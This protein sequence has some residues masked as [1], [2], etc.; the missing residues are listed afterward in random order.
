[1][2][3][4]QAGIKIYTKAMGANDKQESCLDSER[5]VLVT[6]GTDE[7]EL[8]KLKLIPCAPQKSEGDTV[9]MPKAE[10]KSS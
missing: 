8:Q 7:K 5:A 3:S 10:G 9:C 4:F 1:M 6:E 2:N